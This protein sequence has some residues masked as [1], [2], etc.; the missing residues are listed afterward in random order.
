MGGF[1][2]DANW[3]APTTEELVRYLREVHRDQWRLSISPVSERLAHALMAYGDS[4]SELFDIG[5]L[6]DRLKRMLAEHRTREEDTIFPALSQPGLSLEDLHA[7]FAEMRATHASIEDILGQLQRVTFNYSPGP[8][9][10]D[11]AEIRELYS[12]L[13]DMAS[14]IRGHMHV[15]EDRL[16]ELT[17]PQG[18]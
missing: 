2:N 12:A 18:A 10:D 14:D 3:L 15:E 9:G 17:R 1:D 8:S 5:R 4:R 13:R 7:L 6:Y 11:A 16:S